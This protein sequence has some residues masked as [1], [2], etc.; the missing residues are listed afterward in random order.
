MMKLLKNHRHL[1][2]PV[3]MHAQESRTTIIK[4]CRTYRHQW[5]NF[6][7][8][9]PS[10]PSKASRHRGM[11]HWFGGGFPTWNH[12]W[13]TSIFVGTSR[14]PTKHAKMSKRCWLGKVLVVSLW[15]T[16]SFGTCL[17]KSW[18]MWCAEGFF[19]R[20]IRSWFWALQTRL[21]SHE[22]DASR[23]LVHVEDGQTTQP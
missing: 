22:G 1:I 10:S 23:D 3:A 6:K 5:R 20:P 18:K 16:F 2:I 11:G 8:S 17:K 21:C 4:I 13:F 14:F 12:S 7:P 9:N 15:F 19:L